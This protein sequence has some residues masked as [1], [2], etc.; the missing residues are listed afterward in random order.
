MLGKVTLITCEYHPTQHMLVIPLSKRCITCTSNDELGSLLLRTTHGLK[1]YCMQLCVH[2]FRHLETF[3]FVFD[4]AESAPQ[5]MQP[6][7][8]GFTN[9]DFSQERITSAG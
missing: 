9:C 8:E 3:I 5:N 6:P 7:W 1:S 2:W 4:S